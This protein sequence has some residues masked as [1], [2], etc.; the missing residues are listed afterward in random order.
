MVVARSRRGPAPLTV[1][2]LAAL[3]HDALT[4][5]M[6]RVLVAGEISNL[7][8]APSGH[9]YFTLKDHRSQLRCVMFRSAAQLLVFTPADGQQVIVRG[10]VDVYQPRGELQ[11]YVEA[12]EPE[13]RGALQL[14]FEQLKARLAA[15][16]L[17]DDARK[18][19]LPYFPRHVGIATALGGAA[20]RDV[21]VTLRRRCP[22]LH[23]VVRPTKVQGPGA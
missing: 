11:L 16:G 19:P 23:V 22:A 8:P 18:Q 3:I 10:Q 7:R 14:A 12:L 6:G 9:L 20:I 13:G 4:L 21:V 2:Q 17:F 15:E 1:T 5:E